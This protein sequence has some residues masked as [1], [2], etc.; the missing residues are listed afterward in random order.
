MNVFKIIN[1]WL[2]NIH[3]FLCKNKYLI[4]KIT[5]IILSILLICATI[6]G[7]LVFFTYGAEGEDIYYSYLE[8][9]RILSGENPYER[10]LA[11]N[12][13][14]NDKYATY[15]PL[16]YMLS[17]LTQ[18]I[19]L[20]EFSEWLFLWRI[21]FLIFNIGI[22]Y[23]IYDIINSFNLQLIAILGAIVWLFNRWT[24]YVAYIAHLD[25]LPI[26]FLILSLKLFSK[27]KRASFLFFWLSLAL[28]QI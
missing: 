22:A 12:M 2:L 11:G 18:A 26:F 19:G 1:E 23:L 25:F 17:A 4:K 21:I 15:F 7:N 6:Y 10:V 20:K 24:L 3:G 8:G 13:R 16:F 9:K 14:D 5:L 27:H 28:K